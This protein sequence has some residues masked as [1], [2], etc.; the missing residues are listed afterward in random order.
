[1]G[2]LIRSYERLVHNYTVHGAEYQIYE[3]F[4]EDLRR[5]S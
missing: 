3:A 4:D 5:G 2:T 1:M